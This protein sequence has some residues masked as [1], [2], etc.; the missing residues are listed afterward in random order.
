M[1]AFGRCACCTQPR[2]WLASPACTSGAT[3]PGRIGGSHPGKRLG[4]V[5]G[6][7][8]WDCILAQHRPRRFPARKEASAD[9]EVL[10]STSASNIVRQTLRGRPKGRP[11]RSEEPIVC[12]DDR[13]TPACYARV[14]SYDAVRPA[15]PLHAPRGTIRALS[16]VRTDAQSRRSDLPPATWFWHD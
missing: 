7:C 13:C 12:A 8:I 14:G 6:D 16:E 5:G 11:F 10:G 1:P 9:R 4:A 2:C 3:I 15:H